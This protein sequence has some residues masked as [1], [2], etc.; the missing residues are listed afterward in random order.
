V[1]I[2]IDEPLLEIST[3]KVDTEIPAL[4]SGVLLRIRVP[5]GETVPIG[6]VLAII[7]EPHKTPAA[8]MTEDPESDAVEETPQGPGSHYD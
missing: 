8:T 7:M 2:E 3:D 1:P 6:T 5:T 4:T